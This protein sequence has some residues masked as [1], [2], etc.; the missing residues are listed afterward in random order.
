MNV[1]KPATG[2]RAAPGW[3]IFWAAVWLCL[4]L[5][6]DRGLAFFGGAEQRML[7]ALGT[8]GL[9][10]LLMLLAWRAGRRWRLWLLPALLFTVAFFVRMLYFGL[11]DFSG[12]AFT[13]E[14]F[15][16]L[17]AES[18]RVAWQQYSWLFLLLFAG[19][20]LVIAA[21]VLL[22]RWMIRPQRMAVPVVLLLSLV[23]LAVGV[24]VTPEWQLAAAT[25]RWFTP[26]SSDIP[27]ARLSQWQ[28]SPLIDLRLTPKSAL[29]ARS[30]QP[31][32][33]LILLY[34]ESGGLAF[35]ENDRHPDLM[36]NLKR[37]IADHGWIDH[38][39]ASGY[40]TI[41]GLV[42][43]QC[44]SLLPFDKDSE[45]M[46]GSDGL[47]EDMPCLG[48]VLHAAGYQQSYLGGADK[49][50]AGKGRFMQV[51]GYDK[52][53]GIRDW[54][55]MKLYQRKG[56]WGLSDVDLFEQSFKELAALRDSGKPFNLTMLTI[57]THVPGFFYEECEPYGD[58]SERFLN[59]AHC[60]DQLIG[61]WV[62]RLQSEGWLDDDTVLA[63][64][65][66]H[67]VFP[68]PE[69]R[70]LFGDAVV[71][72][73]RLPFIVIGKNLPVPAVAH[74]ASY[75][76]APTLLGLLGVTGNQQF[77]LGRSLLK[78][79]SR[80]DYFVTRYVNIWHEQGVGPMSNDVQRPCEANVGVPG[81]S[82]LSPCERG[83][84]QA[85]LLG[86]ARTLS[87]PR[88][89]L[90][91]SQPD[92]L[93]A[94]IPLDPEQPLSVWVGSSEESSR[95]T[96]QSRRVET[97]RP[98]LYDIGFRGDG[99]LT[100]RR[101][102]PVSLLGE[103]GLQAELTATASTRLVLWRAPTADKTVSL[104]D[105]LHAL[106]VSDA[107]SG[108]LLH[109]GVD[110]SPLPLQR[111]PAGQPWALDPALCAGLVAE[112]EDARAIGSGQ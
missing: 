34:I 107:S 85:L 4:L 19:L 41:E 91:C 74:G 33:N 58:G 80:P 6:A 59:A 43:S 63:I 39:H 49:S 73:K 29:V 11:I 7:Q 15:I 47:V 112:P 99:E 100:Q 9:A 67:Q 109:R 36:P 56:T 92:P 61:Q 21:F 25:M 54:M 101:Y 30:A 1:P 66:D 8:L 87:V 48:D 90:D 78:S 60:S 81:L 83:E 2:A 42:N 10:G 17:S 37:M 13:D 77:A 105:W 102:T 22:P 97:T 44:G 62:D 111:F 84:L 108:V 26:L 40:I 18:V 35:I 27:P 24:R 88:P 69:M 110:D 12:N 50:F 38:L 96:R 104:P 46:A 51:H 65:G 20:G 68:S 79:S 95:F 5:P 45:S 93:M 14:F 57:G 16:H 98:G 31:P 71:D 52:V 23:A 89:R 28:K 103:A 106:G 76:I 75:D 3:W 55:A 64:T 94:S 53:M 72:D 32:R 70:R 82:V 86:Q